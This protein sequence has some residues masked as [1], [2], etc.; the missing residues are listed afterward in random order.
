MAEVL[1]VQ[2]FPPPGAPFLLFAYRFSICTLLEGIKNFP[3]GTD[4]VRLE[5]D[6]G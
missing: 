4:Y 3:Q 1:D 6:M 5:S 2:F